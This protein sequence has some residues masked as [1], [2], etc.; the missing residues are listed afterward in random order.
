M[1]TITRRDLGKFEKELCQRSL[2]DFIRLSWEHV[3]TAPFKDN[4]HVKVL[5]DHLQAMFEGASENRLLINI[6]PGSAKSL[7]VNVF[8]PCWIWVRDNRKRIISASHKEKLAIRD[9]VKCR[10]LIQSDWYQGHW[11]IP[12][13]SDQNAKAS[14]ENLSG[15]AREA[16][17]FGSMT[18]SRGNIV[19]IDDPLSVADAKSPAARDTAAETFLEAIPSRVNDPDRDLIIVV[20]QR[21]HEE[22][23]SGIILSK[24]D[25]GYDHLCI[26]LFADGEVRP[27]TSYGWTD[28]REEGENMFPARYTDKYIKAMQSSLGPFAWAGQ[29]QQRPTPAN[30]GFFN[31]EWFEDRFQ[32]P[33]KDD[34]GGLPTNLHYYITSDHAPSG[35]GDYNVFQIWGVDSSK[36]LWLVDSFRKKCIMDEAIGIVRDA[37]T[38]KTT[39]ADSG[40]LALIRKYKPMAWFP[41]NDNTW[42]AIR[43]FVESAM[44]ET[45]TFARI[46]PLPTKGSGDKMGKAVAFQAMASMRRIHLPAGPVGDELL[47]EF[48]TFPNGKHDDQ[49]DACSAIARALADAMPAM[50]APSSASREEFDRYES[51]ANDSDLCW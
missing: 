13:Q 15:G 44:L 19:I 4:W 47:A 48:A 1:A 21:L 10:R 38:G 33:T 17:P 16:M 34:K 51:V 42:I 41:E 8:F 37:A 30:D 32:L 14:F 27:P 43:G 18:G 11:P 9:S 22:D 40:A 35:N 25:L 3:D 29:Y 5:A 49:V 6:C 45:N 31:R 46:E 50:A 26:P 2:Y 24:P 39:I 12:L 23:I 36:Q 20:M 28:H 7:I